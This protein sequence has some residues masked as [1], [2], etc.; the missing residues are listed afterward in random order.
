[1]KSYL[2]RPDFD[3]STEFNAVLGKEVSLQRLNGKLQ[4]IA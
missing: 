3:A 2:T 1:M 4:S